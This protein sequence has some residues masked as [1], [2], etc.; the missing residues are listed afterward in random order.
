MIV[1]V[2]NKLVIIQSVD[3]TKD[4]YTYQRAPSEIIINNAKFKIL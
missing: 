4:Q 1:T 2:F 3:L